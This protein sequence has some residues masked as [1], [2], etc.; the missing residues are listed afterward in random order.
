LG[1]LSLVLDLLFP[2]LHTAFQI[3]SA[4]NETIKDIDPLTDT[5]KVAAEIRRVREELLQAIR[6]EGQQT[7]AAVSSNRQYWTDFIFELG[8]WVSGKAKR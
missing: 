6:D 5:G 4:M 2:D 1:V 8:R 3:R 7:R